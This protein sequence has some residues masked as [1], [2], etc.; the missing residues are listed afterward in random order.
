M[1][2]EKTG[3]LVGAK[4]HERTAEREACRSGHCKHKL[5]TAFGEIEP[6]IPNLRD[7]RFETA[8]LERCKR[9]ETSAEEAMIEM[10]LA[11]ASA[12]MMEDASEI[13]WG[14]KASAMTISNLNE[15]AFESIRKRH[16]PPLESACPY[17]CADGIYPK[18]SWGGSRENVAATIAIG[19]NEDACRDIIGCAEGLAESK[20]PWKGL[21]PWLRG[22]GL[23]CARMP[24]GDKPL[25]MLGAL[26]EAFPEAKH[27]HCTARLHRDAFGK[28]L[29][30]KRADV[31]KMPKVVHTQE[32]FEASM[33]T[34]VPTCCSAWS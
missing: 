17:V 11:G 18:R 15:K 33:R 3:E 12:R 9:R 28:V 1:P 6:E 30:N 23:Q 5:A 27:R 26:E 21:S 20:K 31:A 34:T 19:V 14:S 2:D 10:H 4:R 16:S 24:T 7:I 22:R 29:K 25:G 32:S 8:I 13:L